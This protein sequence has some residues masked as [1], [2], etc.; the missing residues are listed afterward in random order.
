[1]LLVLNRLFTLSLPT[2]PVLNHLLIWFQLTNL[3]SVHIQSSLMLNHLSVHLEVVCLNLLSIL[4]QLLILLMKCIPV[5]FQSMSSVVNCQLNP[6][7]PLILI[8]NWLPGRWHLTYL[9]LCQLPFHFS[10]CVCL[11]T[12]RLSSFSQQARIWTVYLFRFGHWTC[13]WSICP[14][15]INRHDYELPVCPITIGGP[16]SELSVCPVSTNVPE[17]ELSARE[18]ID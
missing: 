14:V 11:G 8:L 3:L 1:M 16:D 18:T 5:Q 12:V 9:I 15:I 2:H 13:L 4:F 7:L 6:S 17:C 10:Q